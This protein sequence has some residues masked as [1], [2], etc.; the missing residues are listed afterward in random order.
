MP[1]KTNGNTTGYI[2]QAEAARELDLSRATISFLVKTGKLGSKEFL[3]RRAVL[4]SD[5]ENYKPRAKSKQP[6]KAK[7]GKAGKE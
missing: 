2:S 7:K 1:K 3:G 4:R 5:V 6:S